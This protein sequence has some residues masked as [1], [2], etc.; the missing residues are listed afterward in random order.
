MCRC[1][2]FRARA[3]PPQGVLRA[4]NSSAVVHLY[5]ASRSTEW[6]SAGDVEFL[7]VQS[8]PV[9]AFLVR[10]RFAATKVVNRLHAVHDAHTAIAYLEG[11]P[12]FACRGNPDV[13]LLDLE[14]PGSHD[15]LHLWRFTSGCLRLPGAGDGLVSTTRTCRSGTPSWNHAMSRARASPTDKR[16]TRA[17]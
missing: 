9:D 8:D 16:S 11:A 17:R 14:V 12:P 13:V 3:C 10:D 7:L 1:E 2:S 15:V 6:A 4:A 5:L